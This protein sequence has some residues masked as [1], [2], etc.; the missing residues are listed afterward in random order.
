M[1]LRNGDR[2][3]LTYDSSTV[4]EYQGQTS[5]NPQDL[6]VGDQIEALVER[7]ETRVPWNSCHS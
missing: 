2:T 4:V 1:N 3:V 6:E 7:S 5:Y